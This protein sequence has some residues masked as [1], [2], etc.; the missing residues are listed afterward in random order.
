M[1][2]D[3]SVLLRRLLLFAEG[4]RRACKQEKDADEALIHQNRA[5]VLD[6]AAEHIEA[7]GAE[8]KRLKSDVQT[9]CDGSA[10]LLTRVTLAE[11]VVEAA[12]GVV[13]STAGQ[14]FREDMADEWAN[15]IKAL[16]GLEDALTTYD[17]ESKE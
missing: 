4:S 17:E 1:T 10:E 12:R 9:L 3:E 16:I 14:N 2:I 5:L 7:R 13:T 15:G 6:D 8:I 11:C